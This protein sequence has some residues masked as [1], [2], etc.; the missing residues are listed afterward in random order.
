MLLRPEIVEGRVKWFDPSKGFGFITCNSIDGDILIHANVLR[1]FG[2]NSVSDG[3]EI[4]FKVQETM[5]GPQAVEVISV[6]SNP[7]TSSPLFEEG[8]EMSSEHI[9]TLPSYPARIKWFDKV[10]GFGFGNI[11][12]SD[13]DIFIHIQLL[14]ISGFSSLQV[15][16]AVSLKLVEGK[17]GKM[18]VQVLAWDAD[19]KNDATKTSS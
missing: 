15:G 1:N 16:E 11:F 7:L 2:Q 5:R 3:T 18:A 8:E 10:K 4:V 13:E 17:R 6:K 14:H 12:G 9:A 19:L